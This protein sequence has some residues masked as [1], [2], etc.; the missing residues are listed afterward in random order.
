[1]SI[2]PIMILL[3]LVVTAGAALAFFWAVDHDQFDDLQSPAFLPL[4]EEAAPTAPP[5]STPSGN[6]ADDPG[7]QSADRGE[8]A[9]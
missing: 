8:R 7:H 6:P 4:L 5:T 3:S 2:L 9:P 1:M